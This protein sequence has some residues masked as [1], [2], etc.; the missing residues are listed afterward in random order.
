MI[1]K[2]ISYFAP[3]CRLIKHMT[4][5]KSTYQT[6]SGIYHIPKSPLPTVAKECITTI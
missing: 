3:M 4:Q 5:L 1:A 2:I 6:G